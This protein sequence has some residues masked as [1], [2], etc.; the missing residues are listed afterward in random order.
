MSNIIQFPTFA[1]LPCWV[2]QI[3]PIGT[4]E[5]DENIGGGTGGSDQV[6]TLAAAQA[7]AN[8]LAPVCG[9]TLKAQLPP[10]SRYNYQPDPTSPG[11]IF[12][13]EPTQ[14]NIYILVDANGD[15]YGVAEDFIR[16]ENFRGLGYPGHWTFAPL[17]NNPD[18]APQFVWVWDDDTQTIPQQKAALTA[19]ITQLTARLKALG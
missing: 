2:S 9:F 12:G 14:V 5:A 18:K 15:E 4:V 7:Q 8:E 10:A 11:N 13:V 16:Q 3:G 6:C 1:P 17:P 19:Q